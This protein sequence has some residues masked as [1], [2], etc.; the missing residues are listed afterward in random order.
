MFVDL[1]RQF[2]TD[3]SAQ[4]ITEY[5]AILAFVALL[6]AVVFSVANGGLE[7]AISTT[8]SNIA[9]ALNNLN[10]QNPS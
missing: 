6:I 10:N 4:G 1:L 3:R 9:A 5:G 7:N 8:F 2:L